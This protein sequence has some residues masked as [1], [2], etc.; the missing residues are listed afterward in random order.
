MTATAVEEVKN[1]KQNKNPYEVKGYELLDLATQP[2]NAFI[3][4][5]RNE[6]LLRHAK[7]QNVDIRYVEG[8]FERA[9]LGCT[10]AIAVAEGY[11]DILIVD[12]LLGRDKRIKILRDDI[13]MALS[14]VSSFGIKASICSVCGQVTA[15]PEDH[16]EHEKRR[17]N[18][19]GGVLTDPTHNECEACTRRQNRFQMGYHS[20]N[21]LARRVRQMNAAARDRSRAPFLGVEW[22]QQSTS[23]AANEQARAKIEAAVNIDPYNP[24]VIFEGDGSLGSYGFETIFAP[25]Q[26][27]T[28][29]SIDWAAAFELTRHASRRSGISCAYTDRAT[30]MHVHIDRAYFGDRNGDGQILAS[31]A[32]LALSQDPDVRLCFMRDYNDYNRRASHNVKETPL[33]SMVDVFASDRYKAI[34]TSNTNTIE[35]RAFASPFTPEGMRSNIAIANAMARLAKSCKT[36]SEIVRKCDAAHL[37]SY[38]SETDKENIVTHARQCAEVGRITTATADRIGAVFAPKSPATQTTAPAVCGGQA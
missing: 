17:C 10:Y 33:Q 12:S 16:S 18:N 20:G 34:N 9:Y 38:L 22:E 35:I 11:N 27:T 8:R 4:A 19:C 25:M 24:R 7:C 14:P 3:V 30:G 21:T 23:S 28:L 13:D 29:Q 5:V 26:A 6:T 32:L 15:A 31:T 36:V 1:M 37:V 2:K